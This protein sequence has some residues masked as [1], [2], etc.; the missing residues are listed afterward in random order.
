M[1]AL[2]SLLL[3]ETTIITPSRKHD[4]E[5]AATPNALEKVWTASESAGEKNT[6]VIS[7]KTNWRTHSN[8]YWILTKQSGNILAFKT[9][10]NTTPASGRAKVVADKTGI[11]SDKIIF[12]TQSWAVT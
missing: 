6:T 10:E 12:F 9:S 2:L 3:L 8:V 1:K 4:K 7:Y 11:V 5:E